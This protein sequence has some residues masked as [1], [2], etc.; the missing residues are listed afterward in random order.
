[1]LGLLVQ[2]LLQELDDCHVHVVLVHIVR[3]IDGRSAVEVLRHSDA[4][5]IIEEL[6]DGNLILIDKATN[7]LTIEQEASNGCLQKLS[8]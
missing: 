3:L 8:H 7:G 4:I 5:L 1:V 6:S 2:E